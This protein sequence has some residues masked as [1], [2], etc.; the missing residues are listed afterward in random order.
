MR[1]DRWVGGGG[2][3]GAR[4]GIRRSIPETETGN[5]VSHPTPPTEDPEALLLAAPSEAAVIR[6]NGTHCCTAAL[7]LCGSAAPPLRSE[8]GAARRE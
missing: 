1:E 5:P 8:L 4:G 6:L 2:A 7:L 3:R